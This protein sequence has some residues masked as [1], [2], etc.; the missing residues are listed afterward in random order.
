M[1]I[2]N[3][4]GYG[5]SA[6]NTAYKTLDEL[7]PGQ[8]ISNQMDYDTHTPDNVLSILERLAGSEKVN[9]IVGTSFGGFFACCLSSKFDVPIILVNPCLL[10][11]VTLRQT[12]SGYR[13]DYMARLFKL[14]GEHMGQLDSRY[15]STIVGRSDELIDHAATT[16]YL[17]KGRAWYEIDGSHQLERTD[18]LAAAFRDIFEYYH[19]NLANIQLGETLRCFK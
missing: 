17:A 3:I 5:G 7:Y 6:H 16:R 9:A 2:L 19:E 14:F 18:E 13:S 8:V 1:K 10:P 4:H 11:F 12:S 15:L